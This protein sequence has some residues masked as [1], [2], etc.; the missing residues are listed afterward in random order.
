MDSD[1]FLTIKYPAEGFFKD[2]KSRFIGFA[3]PVNNEDSVK[4]IIKKIR[5]DYYDA[6]HRCY[7]YVIGKS[8]EIYRSS[9]DGEQANTAGVQILGQINSRQLTNIL[10]VVVR[11]YGGVKLGI[12]GLI[13]AFRSAATDTLDKSEIITSYEK[14]QGIIKFQYPQMNSVMNILKEDGVE[15]IEQKF[16]LDCIINFEVYSSL[17]AKIEKLLNKTEGVSCKIL[18]NGVTEKIV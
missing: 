12:P 7:A 1:A 14:K 2:R 10:L 5:K 16:E 9:D 3:F 13:H 18:E 11:Y 4:E 15:I 8:R 6:T 17:S